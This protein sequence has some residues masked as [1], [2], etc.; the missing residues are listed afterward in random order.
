MSTEENQNRQNPYYAIWP[1]P[2]HCTECNFG[3]MKSAQTCERVL[4]NGSMCSAALPLRQMMP[5]PLQRTQQPSRTRH[6]LRRDDLPCPHFTRR[7]HLCVFFTTVFITILI[8]IFN[9]LTIFKSIA[10]QV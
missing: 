7:H 4:P 5:V 6:E 1:D 2:G 9:V 8:I 10:R 3:N